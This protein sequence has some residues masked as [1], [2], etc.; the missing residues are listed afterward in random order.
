MS[1]VIISYIHYVVTYNSH[2]VNIY[3]LIIRISSVFSYHICN[4][5]TYNIQMISNDKE[6]L[7]IHNDNLRQ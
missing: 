3:I 6:I 1:T 4:V 2:I 7:Y 5:V